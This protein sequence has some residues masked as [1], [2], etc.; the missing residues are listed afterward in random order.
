MSRPRQSTQRSSESDPRSAVRPAL[1]LGVAA[2]LG[3]VF[4]LRLLRPSAQGSDG[5]VASLL[6]L[7]NPGPS[8]GEASLSLSGISSGCAGKTGQVAIDSRALAPGG[9]ALVDLS[10]PGVSGLPGDCR[11]GGLV[12]G[13]GAAYAA[14]VLTEET[15]A[16]GGLS[17]Y[18]GLTQ[19]EADNVLWLP[20]WSAAAA[21]GGA[22]SLVVQNPGTAPADVAVELIAP[23]GGQLAC[24]ACRWTL[25][26]QSALEVPVGA[27]GALTGQAAGAAR[28]VARQ[29]LLGLA[30]GDPVPDR[31]AAGLRQGSQSPPRL[32]GL[33]SRS[34]LRATGSSALLARG[35]G[36]G[37]GQLHLVASGGTLAG[38][39][40]ALLDEDGKSQPSV[41]LDRLPPRA[42]QALDLEA[43]KVAAGRYAGNLRLTGEQTGLTVTDWSSG[44]ARSAV[45]WRVEGTDLLLP[46]LWPPDAG[47]AAWISVA[48]AQEQSPTRVQVALYQPGSRK[49]LAVA[50]VDLPP[51]GSTTFD[52]SDESLFGKLD[53][54]TPLWAT[55]SGDLPVVASVQLLRQVGGRTALA[56]YEA[57]RADALAKELWLPWL[58]IGAAPAQEAT[59]TA[60]A[61]PPATDTPR[62]T[63]T[64]SPS[65]E[66]GTPT[67]T[68]GPPPTASPAPTDPVLPPLPATA[69]PTSGPRPDPKTGW[70]RLLDSEMLGDA[71]D[72]VRLARTADGTVWCLLRGPRGGRLVAL[73]PR[74]GLRQ[75]ADR[76][77][78]V[79]ADF[80]ALVRGGS[81][82]GFWEVDA[83]GRVWVGGSFFDGQT[84]F[85]ALPDEEQVS[86]LLRAGDRSA[87]AADGRVWVPQEARTDCERPQG[88]GA[89]GL[90]LVDAA[91]GRATGIDLSDSAG[92][93]GQG[94]QL[95]HLGSA[96]PQ[97]LR[98]AGRSTADQGGEAVAVTSQGL[99]LLPDP[100]PIAYPLLGPPA[101][102]AL[103]NAGEATAA[104][105]GPQGLNVITWIEEQQVSGIRTRVY[106]NSW[107]AA[108][109]RWSGSEDLTPAGSP[110]AG[111]VAAGQRVTAA[112]E[113]PD[114]T[115]WLGTD[116]GFLV[117]RRGTLWLLDRVPATA[118][119]ERRIR[120]LSLAANGRTVLVATAEGLF[121]FD[122]QGFTG[123]RPL[124]LPRLAQ[125]G[126]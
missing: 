52:L 116:G 11:A 101:K 7:L 57:L 104:Y 67:A 6:I 119:A 38:G 64:A 35:L 77:A 63:D 122:G 4:S 33:R 81:V 123:V 5:R 21:D 49:A 58:R 88:C 78:G 9:M 53:G 125:S 47:H 83:A 14:L 109:R 43:A 85:Q 23:D 107:D 60:T 102:G 34:L 75:F 114:G 110:L 76:R 100:S 96:G 106:R 92:G 93:A 44:K 99:Y 112:A 115:L 66:P 87:M 54:A 84:W 80:A 111:L 15:L 121:A 97:A 61:T 25:A 71:A 59:A 108:G 41:S 29:P 3:M 48:S 37:T 89:R 40:L 13:S 120:A 22:D 62:V 24:D 113:A 12:S 73:D 42:S 94:T 103:R 2:V 39:T 16:E 117:G 91:G 56:E 20:R 55:V 32:P 46:F 82:P 50:S 27:L 74:G 17:A 51:G 124:Y 68:E 95:L 19:P 30:L 69:V 45:G 126:R 26:P 65:P 105:R 98:L 72:L 31:W 90:R 86:G 10:D 1:L 36:S 79:A 28:V 8:S 18:L 70:R 118:G